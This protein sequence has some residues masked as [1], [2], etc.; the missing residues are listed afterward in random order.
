V[1]LLLW[2]F[3]EECAMFLSNVLKKLCAIAPKSKWGSNWLSKI[4]LCLSPTTT[5]ATAT[6]TNGRVIVSVSKGRFG[7]GVERVVDAALMSKVLPKGEVLLRDGAS[8]VA[9]CP[10]GATAEPVPVRLPHDDAS[11]PVFSGIYKQ[12]C[13]GALDGVVVDPKELALAIA[14][15]SAIPDCKVVIKPNPSERSLYITGR[16]DDCVVKSVVMGLTVEPGGM[17]PEAEDDN[18]TEAEP[19]D[20]SAGDP[21]VEDN[22]Q[23]NPTVEDGGEDDSDP[24]EDN[25]TADDEG[26]AESEDD[27]EEDED[28][29]FNR[30]MRKLAAF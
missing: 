23:D 26:E 14:V 19:V 1:V 3:I 9:V 11:Y 20:E 16:Q 22:S 24:S 13:E 10:V 29:E 2:F 12:H 6:A 17:E 25:P 21:A 27:G 30:I 18:A 28:A 8:D 15:F 4:H 7:S 5:A